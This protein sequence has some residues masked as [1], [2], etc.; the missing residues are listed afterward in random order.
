MSS[1]ELQT[2][3]IPCQV[4]VLKQH[5][6]FGVGLQKPLAAEAV[7]GPALPLQGIHHVKGCDS[8]APGVLCVGDCIPDDVLQEH[9]QGGISQRWSAPLLSWVSVVMLNWW[10]CWSQTR[11]RP[12]RGWTGKSTLR[13]PRVSS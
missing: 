8:L 3:W 12:G 1:P 6:F 5:Q 11:E 13:T 4:V 2:M 7:Q 9:L 10:V